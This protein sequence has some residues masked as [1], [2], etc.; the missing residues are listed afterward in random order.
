MRTLR[1]FPFILLAACSGQGSD[2][3]AVQDS[4]MDFAHAIPAPAAAPAP[5]G[6]ATREVAHRSLGKGVTS[7]A[8]PSAASTG[9]AIPAG[10]PLQT[11]SGLIL[12]KVPVF[13][14][15]GWSHQASMTVTS[16]IFIRNPSSDVP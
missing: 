10:A 3:S 4:S 16:L 2:E 7:V 1:L 15:G 6:I 13:S 5:Q 9:S 8:P 14:V 11:P 12:V